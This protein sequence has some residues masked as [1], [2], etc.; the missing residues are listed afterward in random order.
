METRL[1]VKYVLIA[2]YAFVC[3]SIFYSQASFSKERKDI[4]FYK[5]N[6]DEITQKIRFTNR[7]ARKPGCHNFIK[8]VRLH[9]TVQF[10]YQACRVYSKK[11]CKEESVMKFYRE[12]EPEFTTAELTQ[13]YGW[14]PVGERKRGERVKSWS[15]E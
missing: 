4:R 5:I 3:T 12:K 8:K 10:G 2:S 9:R 6:K 11:N 14:Y 1:L 15:C 7:K 13:G